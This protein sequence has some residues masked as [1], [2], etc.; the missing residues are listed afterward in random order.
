MIPLQYETPHRSH[1]FYT[2]S[3]NCYHSCPITLRSRVPIIISSWFI[4]SSSSIHPQTP[5]SWWL[6]SGWFTSLPDPRHFSL[7][8]LV[9]CSW[10]KTNTFYLNSYMNPFLS[11]HPILPLPYYTS[12]PIPNVTDHSHIFRVVVPFR[13]PAPQPWSGGHVTPGSSKPYYGILVSTSTMP[14]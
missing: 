10:W 2:L 6:G 11:L 13:I 9:S 5:C 12:S 14:M 8:R 4:I 7:L 3:T 1:Q